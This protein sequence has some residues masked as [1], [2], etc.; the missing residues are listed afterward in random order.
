MPQTKPLAVPPRPIATAH[1]FCRPTR[2]RS[3][4]RVQPVRLPGQLIRTLISTA[5]LRLLCRATTTGPTS[6]LIRS[7]PPATIFG[8]AELNKSG[9]LEELNKSGQLEELNKSGQL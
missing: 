3:S 1:L 4:C 5:R 8:P 2:L 9:Q 6:S 7:A